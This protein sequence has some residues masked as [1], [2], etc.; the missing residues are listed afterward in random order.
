M[1]NT[2]PTNPAAA[3]PAQ[4]VLSFEQ[5]RLWL[6]EQ[7]MPAPS[8]I[9]NISA[10]AALKGPLDVEALEQ[11]F[12]ERVAR[13]EVLRTVYPAA[14]GMPAP[15][16]LPASALQLSFADLSHLPAGPCTA[17]AKRLAEEALNTPFDL[18]GG[19]LLRAALFCL[20][21]AHHWLVLAAHHIV[22]DIR[23]LGILLDEIA[24]AY[25]AA[26]RR[27]PAEAPAAL[28]PFQYADFA[29]QQRQTGREE[30]APHL[31]YWKRQLANA[32]EAPLL[33]TDF[34]RSAVPGQNGT[35]MVFDLP[36][37]SVQALRAWSR[38]ERAHVFMSLLAAFQA[39]LHVFSGQ[40]DIWVGSPV[41]GRTQPETQNLAGFFAYP[42]ILRTNLAG[43][44]TLRE[45]VG[46]VSA[47]AREAYEHQAIPFAQIVRAAQPKR[48]AHQPPPF[49]VMFS[50][51]QSPVEGIEMP[52]L[53]LAWI[54]IENRAT[55]FDL[56][57]T[58]M[59]YR[60]GLHANLAYR[61]DLF[62]PETIKKFAECY[63]D[64]LEQCIQ[65]PDLPL[66]QLRP[67]PPAPQPQDAAEPARHAPQTLALTATFTAEPLKPGLAFWM[68]ELGFPTAI[69]F[70]PYNQVFQ[71]LLN[72]NSLLAKNLDGVNVVLIRFEDWLRFE[73]LGQ[74]PAHMHEKIERHTRDLA[75]AL[76]SAAG[77]SATPHIVC[78]CP[79]S[80]AALADAGKAALFRRLEEYLAATLK[81]CPGVYL[82]TS[83]ELGRLYPVEKSYDAYT[84]QLGHAPYTT[85]GFTALA[86]LLARRVYALRIPP[87]KVI[88]LDC[89][90][91]LWHGVCGEVGPQGVEISHPYRQLQEMMVA[92]HHAGRLLCLCSKNNA[93]DVWEVFDH[94]P[95][96]PLKREHILAWK[97][98]WQPK[99]LNLRALAEDLQLGIDSL[100]F[101]DDNP[102]E[103]A[104][105]Q[106]AC[107]EVLT[108]QLPQEP[109]KLSRFLQHVWAF[110]QLKVTEEDRRRTHLYRQ[111]I[112]RQQAL[113][114]SLSF[115]DFLAGLELKVH[116]APLAPEQIGR[117]AQ[118]TQRTNQ[119][120]ATTIRRTESEIQQ[121]SQSQ[122]LEFLTVTVCDRF[123]DYGLVGAVAF[124]T[125]DHALHL[126]TFL[127]SCRVLGRGVEH[128]MMQYLGKLAL[129]RGCTQLS[130][131]Y[132]PTSR[133]QPALAFLNSIGA[134]QRQSAQGGCLFH[135]AAE[136]A[137]QLSYQPG[138][139]RN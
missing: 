100:I 3:R 79:P 75:L 56:F 23:S 67:R 89:D 131:P 30:Q 13:H 33:P 107:P 132:Q 95:D 85:A 90:H 37:G 81:G 101:I 80:P 103:C 53:D 16:V 116:I 77:R 93:A 117:V 35:Q 139:P 102:L 62:R 1:A 78:V 11:A 39:T 118:L 108:V 26:V 52:A 19:P 91:T 68:N 138:A 105:V 48:R 60:S 112:A 31:A 130:I 106:A 25:T 69:E 86:T 44:P 98:D 5:E 65:R 49:Q 59:E 134:S 84:D 36:A 124:H 28:R 45:L 47:V 6:V 119:F 50:L 61:R 7:I 42:L 120:N 12:A 128:Q 58:L 51:V 121:I 127:L 18:A 17:E 9:H 104:E 4:C 94:R 41:S 32:P 115:E 34:P 109:E 46:R 73:S 113:Q 8:P 55:E 88:V 22:A 10:A 63:Q 15:A 110:D 71:Q 87:R 126:D 76:Q 14:A 74:N 114:A 123:G 70:A 21:P 125:E 135:I 24:A 27:E 40:E 122:V 54:D 20:A 29:R 137:Q 82:T 99:S 64:I 43:D 83:A 57:L 96:M 136:A 72:P 92:Q 97:I 129:E 38:Q 133:N 2:H 111:N 66:S